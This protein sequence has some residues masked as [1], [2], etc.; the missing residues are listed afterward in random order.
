MNSPH[1][2]SICRISCFS[3]AYMKTD[4]LGRRFGFRGRIQQPHDLFEHMHDC[5][6][7]SI[8][9]GGQHFLQFRKLFRQHAIVGQYLPH[10]DEG[11]HDKNAHLHGLG[12]IEHVR[13]PGCR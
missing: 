6:L 4:F 13:R 5:P 11:P 7:V 8:K 3:L 9:P 1:S 12:R 10:A 2:F